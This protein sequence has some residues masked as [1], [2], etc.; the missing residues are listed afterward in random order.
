MNFL[1]AIFLGALQGL[2]EFLPV[3]SSAHLVFAQ[4]LIP[5]FNQ[6]GIT[7]DVILHFGTF[8]A[9]IFYFR[10]KLLHISRK[11]ILYLAIGT[12]PAVIIGLFF[13][14]TIELMFQS[15]KLASLALI[16]TGVLNLLTDRAK[17]KNEKINGKKSLLVGLSQAIAIIPGISR[18]GSTIFAGVK[19]GLSGKSA[20][21]FSFLLSLPAIL[22]A[23]ILEFYSHGIGTIE[24]PGLYLVG[25]FSA[26][27]AGLA[28][29]R[30]VIK[31]LNEK[32]F[33]IFAYYCFI[34]GIVTFL[35]L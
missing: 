31:F 25:F 15:A 3:S 4:S 30:L 14:D 28:A 29:I 21:E 16:V 19:S 10:K 33:Q 23:N 24:N 32:R 34:V 22:G 1:T 35:L 20:A 13:Q 11:Y 9:V 17:P 26:L 2:T 6:V 12:I 5:G 7:F 8:F 27:I 18:S